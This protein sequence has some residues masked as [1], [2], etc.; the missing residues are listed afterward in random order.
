[1]LREWRS[2]KTVGADDGGLIFPLTG[3]LAEFRLRARL[4]RGDCL[5]RHDGPFGRAK[6]GRAMTDSTELDT[7]LQQMRSAPDDAALRLRFL[8]ELLN[9]ELY[10]LLNEEAREDRLQ[11]RVFDLAEARAVL[12]FDSEARMAAFAGQ[13]V[14]YAALPGRVLVTMLAGAGEDLSLIVNADAPHAELLPPEAVDWLA[15]TLSAPPP[16]EAE[17][18]APAFAPPALPGAVLALLV[19]A[20][21]RRLSGVPGLQAAVLAAVRW[22]DGAAGHVLALAGVVPPARPALARAVAEALEMSGLED[23][24][25]DVIFPGPAAMARIV[26]VGRSLSPA[27][28][29]APETEAA[30]TKPPVGPGMDPSRPPRL[31]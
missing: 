4:A 2:V 28:R 24:A 7:A 16:V 29:V 8:A 21:E 23:G 15:A 13:A 9:S 22:Q 5:C 30:G 6:P 10:V 19:P 12:V 11:P 25:L 17:A 3:P 18:V 31:K 14:A 27:P 1:L 20:L 26:E